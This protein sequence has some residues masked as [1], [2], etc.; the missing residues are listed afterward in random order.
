MAF[1]PEHGSSAAF[2][3]ASGIDRPPAV[4]IPRWKNYSESASLVDEIIHK[5]YSNLL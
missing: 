2:I 5:S 1:E 3:S 4:R